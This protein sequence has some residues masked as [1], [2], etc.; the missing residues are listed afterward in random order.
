MLP[1]GIKVIKK[2]TKSPTVTV[3]VTIEVGSGYE[4]KETSGYAHFLE[5][6]LFEGTKNKSNFDIA[7]EVESL[8]GEMNGATN[9][10]KTIYYIK[11]PKAYTQSAVNLLADMLTSPLFGKEEFKKEK[12]VIQSEIA[13][14]NDDPK[15]FGWLLLEKNLFDSSLSNPTLGSKKSISFATLEKLR[16]FYKKHYLGGNTTITLTG[17]F[18]NV[19]LSPFNSLP[20]GKTKK[21]FK[22]PKIK[23][24]KTITRK[25]NIAQSYL[26]L[27]YKTPGKSVFI[28]AVF[29]VIQAHLGRGASGALF[30]ELRNKRGIGYAVHV[31]ND[32]GTHAGM[33]A[34]VVSCKKKDLSLVK[35]IVNQEISKCTSLTKEQLNEAKS[36][37]LG[38]LEMDLEDTRNLAEI[39]T[40]HS[41]LGS[42]IQK[43]RSSVKQITREDISKVILDYLSSGYCIIV[44]QK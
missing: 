34:V 14:Y 30:N 44:G 31:A 40:N 26:F 27:G 28:N 32:L 20:K 7:N 38:R 21:Q 23:R 37:V 19:D 41:L 8:G 25:K 6:M 9:S 16:T 17:N 2:K 18:P 43:Y 36:H 12:Q 35:T 3:L 29:D 15:L 5:H 11:V 22:E 13:L 24:S 33:F 4:T 39:V 42:S 10:E 1:N